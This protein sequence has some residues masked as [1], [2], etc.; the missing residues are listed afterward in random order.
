MSKLNRIRT[1]E[2]DRLQGYLEAAQHVF[3]KGNLDVM[4]EASLFEIVDSDIT[5]E[6]V[7]RAVYPNGFNPIEYRA[8]CSFNEMVSGVHRILEVTREFWKPEYSIPSMIEN[9]VR[10]GYWKHVKSCFDYTNARI[11]ELGHNV[12]YVNVWGGFTYILYAP[13]MRRCL[14]LV[15]NTS[16]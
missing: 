1:S 7:V 4:L 13:D 2:L 8:E 10:E 14:L 3:T 11:V 16:D 5:D 15:G 6:D 12:P 9:N